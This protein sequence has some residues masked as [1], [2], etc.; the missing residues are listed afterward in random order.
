[1]K[2]LLKSRNVEFTEINMADDENARNFVIEKTGHLSSPIIQ[3][4]DEFVVGFDKKK[5]ESLLG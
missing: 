5:I 2:D 4:G 1:V 3:I